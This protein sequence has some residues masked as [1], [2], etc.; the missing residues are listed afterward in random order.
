MGAYEEAAGGQYT[1]MDR[2]GLALGLVR[3]RWSL[4]EEGEQSNPLEG[5]KETGDQ[6]TDYFGLQ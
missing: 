4:S 1:Y 5:D 2:R 3:G 6:E